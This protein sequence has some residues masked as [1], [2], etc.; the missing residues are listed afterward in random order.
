MDYE[1]AELTWENG[2]VV[3]HGLGPRRVPNK[4]LSTPSTTKYAWDNKPHAAAGGT[5]ESIVNQATT[6]IPHHHNSPVDGGGDRGDDD[7]VSWFDDCLPEIQTT[8]AIDT[9]AVDALVPTSS[10]NTP[11][12]NQQVAP[13]THVSGTGMTNKCLVDCS[14]CVASCSGDAELARVGIGSS[15]EEISKDFGITESFG[16]EEVKSLIESMVYEGR[17]N[18]MTDQTVSR[19]DTIETGERSL[20]AE[21]VLTTTSTESHENTFKHSKSKTVNNHDFISHSRAQ[22]NRYVK[23]LDSVLNFSVNSHKES[24]DNEDEDE[25]KGSKISSFS[26]K[27]SRAAATHNQS[28]RKRKDKINQRMKTLQKFVPTSSK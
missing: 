16:N 26:T 1:L 7:F 8:T 17:H 9:I 20:G 14:T 13:S 18:N 19:G 28:E 25:K 2:Q 10:T 6:G 27:R 21:K 11:N 24:K 12:Y 23:L 22:V 3:M 4:P 15:F 5:L